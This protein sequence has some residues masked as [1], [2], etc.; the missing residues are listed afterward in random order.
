[1][2]KTRRARRS[3]KRTSPTSIAQTERLFRQD[4]LPVE[5]RDPRVVPAAQQEPQPTGTAGVG[6]AVDAAAD[7]AAAAEAGRRVKPH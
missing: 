5:A 6:V 4:K 1:M 3:T 7:R 2:T